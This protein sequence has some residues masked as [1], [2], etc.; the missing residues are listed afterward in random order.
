MSKAA[1]GFG[2]D[3]R[4]GEDTAAIER[5][6]TPEFRNR[7]DSI[8]PFGPLSKEVIKTVVDKF[9][10]EIQVQLDDK[11]VLLEVSDAARAWLG[12][13]GYDELLGARPMQRL[14]QEKI[15]R[16]LAEDLLFGD[17]TQGGVVTVGVEDGELSVKVLSN[18][19]PASGLRT[20]RHPTDYSRKVI[21]PLE[22]S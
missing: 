18:G 11:K 3:R 8:I 2:R 6:F 19:A 7:L 9:L 1:I 15:K 12:E 4:E 21:R 22:R 13:Q 14:I 5:T 16:Q 17:L 10:V 20:G